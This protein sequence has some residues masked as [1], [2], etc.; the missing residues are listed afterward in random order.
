VKQVLEVRLHRAY[1]PDEGPPGKRVLVDRVWPR[2]IK[3]ESLHL[4]RWL[5]ELRPSR[6]L[7]RWFGHRPERWEEFRLRYRAELKQ[8]EL[9]A[10]AHQGSLILLYGAR[11]TTHNQAVLIREVLKKLAE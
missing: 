8:Q 7:R 11:D 9:L 3:K 4:D 1:E 2:G 5:P 10:P 6:D